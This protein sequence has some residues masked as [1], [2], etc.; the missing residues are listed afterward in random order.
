M[1]KRVTSHLQFSEVAQDGTTYFHKTS[2]YGKQ[3]TIQD[4]ISQ[5][6]AAIEEIDGTPGKNMSIMVHVSKSIEG[7]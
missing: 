1:D 3:Y 5:V 4:V 2:D 6:V 7:E